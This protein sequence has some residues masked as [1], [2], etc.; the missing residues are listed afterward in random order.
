[1]PANCRW[2][3]IRRLKV[4]MREFSRLAEK[5]RTPIVRK[6]VSYHIPDSLQCKQKVGVG[7]FQSVAIIS[8][9]L[10]VKIILVISLTVWF[11]LIFQNISNFQRMKE[12]LGKR[13]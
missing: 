10:G 9:L 6:R 7:T 11:K 4:K 12:A 3:L 13:S 2:D 1:M 8:S 5:K